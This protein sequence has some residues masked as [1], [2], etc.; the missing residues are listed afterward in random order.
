M[1]DTLDIVEMCVMDDRS[2][3]LAYLIGSASM[4]LWF[5]FRRLGP[6]ARRRDNK[7]KQES[8]NTTAP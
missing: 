3:I 5:E 1:E 4:A 2:F 6:K 7:A 8:G